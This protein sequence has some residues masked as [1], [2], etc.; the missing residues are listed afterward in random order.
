MRTK[1]RTPRRFFLA[2]VEILFLKKHIGR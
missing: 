1:R 2:A